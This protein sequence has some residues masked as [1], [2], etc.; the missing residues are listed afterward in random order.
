MVNTCVCCG[1]VIPEDSQ[2]CQDCLS[3]GIKCPE[4][5]SVL[6]LVATSKGII[7]DEFIV[8]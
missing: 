1:R 2:V 4:C 5:G 6:E 3:Q 7:N 8:Y